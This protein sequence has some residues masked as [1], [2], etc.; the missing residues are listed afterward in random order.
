MNGLWQTGRGVAHVI[1]QKDLPPAAAV[2]PL[3]GPRLLQRSWAA[4]TR[5]STPGCVLRDS[6]HPEAGI[7]VGVWDQRGTLG[8]LIA[9]LPAGLAEASWGVG[10]ECH[11]SVTPSAQSCFRLSPL[12]VLITTD[13]LHSSSDP[14]SRTEAAVG[15]C[16]MPG[17]RRGFLESPINPV[18]SMSSSPPSS[19]PSPPS[20]SLCLPQPKHQVGKQA[21]NWVEMKSQ[22][23]RQG[24]RPK[25]R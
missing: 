12:Q 5:L 25:S 22:R 16:V 15:L 20:P 9:A 24:K 23:P 21:Q 6:W 19:S 14:P 8:R 18:M 17:T 10:G 11:H 7:Q 2:W 4:K 13:I 3:G 1:F